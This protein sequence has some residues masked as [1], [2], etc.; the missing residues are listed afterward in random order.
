MRKRDHLTHKDFVLKFLKIKSSRLRSRAEAVILT[1]D[2]SLFH[3][4]P[5]FGSFLWS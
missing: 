4:N 1:E 5:W 3:T 2:L